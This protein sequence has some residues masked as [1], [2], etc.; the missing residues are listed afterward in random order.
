MFA[1]IAILNQATALDGIPNG[2]LLDE[3]GSGRTRVVALWPTRAEAAAAG[4][5]YEVEEDLA[6]PDASAVPGAAALLYFDGPQSP[7]R[8]EAAR[9]AFRDRIGPLMRA[10]PGCVRTLGLWQ[11]ESCAHAVL[12]VA[13]SLDALAALGEAV[14]T[15]PLLPGEDL[16]LLPG[17]DRVAINRVTA[18]VEGALA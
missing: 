18:H 11:P 16:A 12:N 2:Y 10:A 4:E 6:G 13:V 7:P 17:P 15:S 3:V 1:S 8:I 14:N 5:V 9:R